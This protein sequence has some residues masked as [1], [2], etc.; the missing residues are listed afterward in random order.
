MILYAVILFLT[1]ALFAVIAALIH[2]GKTELIHDYHQT[3]VTD[4]RG[5]GRA[6]GKAMGAM[7]GAMALSG[8][9]ALLGQ[10]AAWPAVAVLVIGLV[11]G[12]IAL[13]AVQKKYNGGVL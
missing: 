3:K 1:A 2:K 7:A 8:G 10:W 11:G 12:I 4:K 9:V 6:F 5:Y 13:V